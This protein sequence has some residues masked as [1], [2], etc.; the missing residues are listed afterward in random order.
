MG[1]KKKVGNSWAGAATEKV[2]KSPKR[3]KQSTGAKID[4]RKTAL[5][6]K[7]QK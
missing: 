1:E 3:R 5:P 6:L 7:Q 2:T 4:Q